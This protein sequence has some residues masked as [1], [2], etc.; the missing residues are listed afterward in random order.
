MI[1]L[2]NV[3]ETTLVPHTAFEEA[4]RRIEQCF[5]YAKTASEPICIAIVGESRT[6]KSRALEECFSRHPAVRSSEGL[7]TPILRVT[8]PPRPSV[9][10]LAETMLRA[11]KDPRPDAGKESSKTAR[12]IALME[13]TGTNMVMIDEFQHFYDKGLHSVMHYV[14]DW[15]KTVVDERKCALVV[16]GLPT[17]LAVLQQNEQLAGRFLSPIMLPRFDWHNE[18]HREE[19]VAILA[20]F[21]ESLSG[22]FDLPV[23]DGPEMAFRCYCGTGGLIGYLTKF[24]RQTVLNA[25]DVNTRVIGLADLLRAHQQAIWSEKGPT[26]MP[27]P[28]SRGFSTEPTDDVIARIQRIGTPTDEIPLPNRRGRIRPPRQSV[29][30]VLSAR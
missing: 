29:Q 3:V 8:T 20:A 24:L 15:L 5:D 7:D 2:R 11:M 16:A 18:G 27:S 17:C 23:L 6:G 12:L 14:A 1:N 22:H 21:Q 30:A 10:N 4:T 28:F 25:L 13:N 26:T 19:F 9:L